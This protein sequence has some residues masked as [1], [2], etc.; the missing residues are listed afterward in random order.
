MECVLCKEAVTNPVCAS[1]LE[2]QMS[3]WLNEIK[4]DLVNKLKEKTNEVS[5]EFDTVGE[6]ILCNKDI[7][8]CAYC[9]TEHIFNWLIDNN[10]ELAKKFITYF[11]FDLE[12]RGYHNKAEKLGLII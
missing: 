4:P 8:L 7:N 1:C 6:C 12:H 9:Y 11:N 5:F 10:R 3:I 2:A